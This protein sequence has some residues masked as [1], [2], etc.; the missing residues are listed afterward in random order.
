MKKSI[1]YLFTILILF[2]LTG[3]GN[4]ATIESFSL[5]GGRLVE[6]QIG[7][8][9]FA[10]YTIYVEYSDGSIKSV[11]LSETMISEE[12]L[13]LIDVIGNHE[14]TI[15]YEEI[16][17]N[18]TFIVYET[19][20][21]KSLIS[22]YMEVFEMQN[23]E[24]TYEE[25]LETLKGDNGLGIE[26][27]SINEEGHL[28]IVYD[29][30]STQD[31]GQVSGSMEILDGYHLVNFYSVEGFIISSQLVMDGSAAIMDNYTVPDGY[32]FEAWDKDFSEVDSDM[33][34]YPIY[35]KMEF[36]VSFVTYN[37]DDLNEIENIEYNQTISLPQ[38]EKE[39]YAFLGWFYD[40]N[41][42]DIFSALFTSSTKV[43][44]NL[45]LFASWEQLS[46]TVEYLN[47]NN[48]VLTVGTFLFG[49]DVSMPTMYLS[50]YIVVD[51]WYIDANYETLFDF[52]SMPA[53]DV[54][55]YARYYYFQYNT[56]IVEGLGEVAVIRE[57]I[58]DYRHVNV[59]QYIDGYLVYEIAH[60]AFDNSNFETITLPDTLQVISSNA[61]LGCEDLLSIVIPDSVTSIGDFA[62]RDNT[63]L[64]SV[65]LSNQLTSISWGAFYDTPSLVSINIP[66]G[67]T[68]INA[69]AF[70]KSAFEHIQLPSTLVFIGLNA[71]QSTGLIDIEIPEGVTQ[72]LQYTF[73][74]CK[75]L[76]SVIL[77]STLSTIHDSLFHNNFAL[78]SIYVNEGNTNYIS[79]EGVLYTAGYETLLMYPSAKASTSYNIPT[80]TTSIK[81]YA[82][83]DVLYLQYITMPSS[84]SF[85]SESNFN[86]CN[87]LINLTTFNTGNPANYVSVN[88]VL[89]DEEI[90][91]LIKYPAKKTDIS[92]STPITVTMIGF[93][94]FENV[95]Y[96]ESV[97]INEGVLGISTLAF[98]NAASLHTVVLP[99]TLMAISDYAFLNVDELSSIYIPA[100]TGFI[101]KY[102]FMDCDSLS[103]II[104]DSSNIYYSSIEG[105]LYN[106]SATS[107]MIYPGG[108]TN[109]EYTIIASVDYI[110][111]NA[112][113]GNDYLEV[114]I[115]PASVE[116]I[117]QFAFSDLSN[118]SR[119]EILTRLGDTLIDIDY[120]AFRE[121]PQVTIYF[122]AEVY[123]DYYDL[124]NSE[125]MFLETISVLPE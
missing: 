70:Y 32:I 121:V 102:A 107:L 52:S 97:I 89:F 74:D 93:G 117:A 92:Y 96:L 77:P 75:E 55:L 27:V 1:I 125:Y 79:D 78:E 72:L 48:A 35:Q 106:K 23:T 66:E 50:E 2:T 58:G 16:D 49:E 112:F 90:S 101:S 71:F 68:V 34:V 17:I 122:Y 69:G 110:S 11:P 87:E 73:S 24:L 38:I 10:D 82:L 8:N 113:L 95:A 28:I 62:F 105:V 91:T 108:K 33:S 124:L 25:W 103:I 60:A 45:V 111:E 13:D 30:D 22:I 37:G 67:V 57:Y 54:I 119:V 5:K 61:F 84:I 100:N 118:L 94:A 83:N 65:V 21:E 85:S 36:T 46:F 42:D 31:V 63:S 115:I 114:I 20:V 29:D 109:T 88:G 6:Y 7:T 4:K 19:M 59:P 81:D 104:V 3:C 51:G 43:T 9:D 86:E 120:F 44:D 98:Y 76:Q 116:Q 26:S 41:G 12:D 53:N 14:I 80:A 40:D 18:V 123:Q 99:S 56:V 47:Y 39:G 64:Q 15:T